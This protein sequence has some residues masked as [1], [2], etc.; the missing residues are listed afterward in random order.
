M[1]SSPSYLERSAITTLLAG[2]FTPAARVGVLARSL[3][4][5]SR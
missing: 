2:R 3:T 4:A 5:L 1:P